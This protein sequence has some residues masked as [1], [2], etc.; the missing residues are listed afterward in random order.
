M[1]WELHMERLDI[2]REMSA[3][4][5]AMIY[6]RQRGRPRFHITREQLVFLRN[7]SFPWTSIAS[8]LS[9]MTRYIGDE[10]HMA[11]LLKVKVSRV[12]WNWPVLSGWTKLTLAYR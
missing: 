1:E 9:R 7:L 12:I 4:H 5:P 2:Q 3:Y 10:E 8:L 11:W 6:R